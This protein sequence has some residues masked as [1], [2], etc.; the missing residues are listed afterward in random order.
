MRNGG[1]SCVFEQYTCSVV[2][3]VAR[4][5]SASFTILVVDDTQA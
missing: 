3:V 5:Y 4:L 1:I 2:V